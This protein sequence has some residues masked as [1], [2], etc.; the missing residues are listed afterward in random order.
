MLR[1]FFFF[2]VELENYDSYDNDGSN[3][4][5]TEMVW[6]NGI[7]GCGDSGEI[8]NDGGGGGDNIDRW[9]K[10]GGGGNNNRIDNDSGVLSMAVVV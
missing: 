2:L 1:V 10:W 4:L 3:D 6:Y 5:I 8:V 9:G 7:G